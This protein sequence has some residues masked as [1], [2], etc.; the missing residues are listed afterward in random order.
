MSALGKAKPTTQC[1]SCMRTVECRE[2]VLPAGHGREGGGAAREAG[3][4]Q[5]QQAAVPQG[6]AGH[7]ARRRSRD[8]RGGRKHGGGACGASCRGFKGSTDAMQNLS[9]C[10][11]ASTRQTAGPVAVGNWVTSA[12]GSRAAWLLQE[13]R[14]NELMSICWLQDRPRGHDRPYLGT[15]RGTRAAAAHQTRCRRPLCSWKEADER[16]G[17]VWRLLAASAGL[18]ARLRGAHVQHWRVR[19]CQTR[20][21]KIWNDFSAGLTPTSV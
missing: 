5:D 14:L 15:R 19:Y 8:M 20:C 3:A 2:A 16:A 21:A 12:K 10:C 18:A 4:E 1:M 11:N 9:R 13:F 17:W 7:N 6:L